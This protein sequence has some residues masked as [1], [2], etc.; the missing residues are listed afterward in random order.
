MSAY[1]LGEAT[2]SDA[3]TTRRLALDAAL[4]AESA[5][6]DALAANARLHLDAHMIWAFD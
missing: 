5:Q 4:A 1:R 3:L 6:I 2:L